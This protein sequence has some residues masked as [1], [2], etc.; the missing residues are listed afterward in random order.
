MKNFPYNLSDS[1]L[2]DKATQMFDAIKGSP[3]D[4]G[5]TAEQ[6]AEFEA[7]TNIF[8][9]DLTAHVAAQAAARSQTQ[10]KEA[11]REAVIEAMSFLLKQAKLNKVSEAKIAEMGAPVGGSTALPPTATKPVGRID[12]SERFRHVIH[13]ADES[14]PNSKRNPRGVFGCE[15]YVKIGGAP[16]TGPAECTALGLDRKTPYLSEFDA[17]DVGKMAHYMLRWQLTDETFSPW[18]ETI[19][20]TVT[21]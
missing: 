16:P 11:S 15:I 2:V 6:V 19:S 14:T 13:F 5:A 9:D 20:A 7:K 1:E 12:T 4:F 3:A 8:G 17:E 21:G 18:S 10:T